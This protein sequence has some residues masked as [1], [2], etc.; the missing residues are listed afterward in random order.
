[1]S[2]YNY[3]HHPRY[4]RIWFAITV[5]NWWCMGN[6]EK[7]N[8][9]KGPLVE[10]TTRDYLL[11]G[12]GK[13]IEEAITNLHKLLDWYDTDNADLPENVKPVRPSLRSRYRYWRLMHQ[14]KRDGKLCRI[15]EDTG[16]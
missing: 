1:M 8:L 15:T 7:E 9:E 12:G 11:A 5:R 13:T 4:G 3:I 6:S 10:I 2:Y 16:R 14:M